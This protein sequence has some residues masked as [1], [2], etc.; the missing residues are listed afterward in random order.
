MTNDTIML[1]EDY[2]GED[3]APEILIKEGVSYDDYLLERAYTY[4]GVSSLPDKD[5]IL[6]QVP[7]FVDG[8][9]WMW[10]CIAC[11]VGIVVDMDRDT[12]KVSP[13]ICP[14]CAYQGWV[15]VKM[16][17]NMDEIE[18]ELLRQPG[19][20]ASTAFRNWEPHWDMDY[21]R[22]R[23]RRAQEQVNA[24][25][26]NP[27]GASIGA[28]RLWSVGEVLTAGNK[29]TFERQVLRDLAGREG[30]IGPYENAIVLYNGT[31]SQRN[32]IP[33]ES[34]MMMYNTDTSSVNIYHSNWSEVATWAFPT[35]TF[36][37]GNESVQETTIP[38]NLGRVPKGHQLYMQIGGS[39]VVQVGS[40]IGETYDYNN[41]GGFLYSIY[42]ETDTN[43]TVG[44]RIGTDNNGNS[45]IRIIS[46]DGT[47][48][49][50]N[51]Y[52]NNALQNVR[53]RVSLWG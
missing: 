46:S 2:K 29:N 25:V 50:V 21:L 38:H 30:P 45:K 12:R 35:G 1:F 19:R 47:V 10:Q 36:Y 39:D 20:R 41:S 7:A 17:E 34:G 53:F 16:P 4:M 3:F 22:H 6:A 40:Y 24:G 43:I 11:G 23:T 31:T 44:A 13:S 8:G 52:I 18:E 15:N 14:S 33:A 26:P 49:L 42:D 5:N 27:R 48:H 28:T 32:A 9:R 51:I 37:P